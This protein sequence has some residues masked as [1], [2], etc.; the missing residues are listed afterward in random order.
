MLFLLDNIYVLLN[1]I[2][3]TL[4]RSWFSDSLLSKIHET[5]LTK[6]FIILPQSKKQLETIGCVMLLMLKML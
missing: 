1:K 4:Q 6:I 3:K 2:S 5:Y